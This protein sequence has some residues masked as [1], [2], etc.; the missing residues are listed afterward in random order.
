MQSLWDDVGGAL[1]DIVKI[2]FNN[3][4]AGIDLGFVNSDRGTKGL[5]RG[6]KGT[7]GIKVRVLSFPRLCTDFSFSLLCVR[8]ANRVATT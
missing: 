2:V 1:Q 8:L 3:D 5:G 7:G 4:G 6:Q